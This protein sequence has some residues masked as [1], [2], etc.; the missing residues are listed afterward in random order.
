MSPL[1][2]IVIP[3][4]NAREKL[5]RSLD[6]IR[7]QNFADLEILVQDGASNDGTPAFLAAQ[8]DVLW[9]SE[10]D[11]GVYDAMNRAIARSTG[12]FLYFLGAGDCL[13]TGVID[14]IANVKNLHPL[15]L[16]YG[17]VFLENKGVEYGTHFE[18]CD[19]ARRNIPHQGAFYGRE[20]FNLLGSFNTKYSLL[21]DHDLNWRCFTNPRVEKRFIDL[22][23]A[24]Y[25]G[26][27]LSDIGVDLEFENDWPKLVWK[28]G[29]LTP[30][31]YL[32]LHKRFST[33]FLRKLGSFRSFFSH[34]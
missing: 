24:D 31:L 12:C 3:T 29:G 19:L 32:Q 33:K 15:L 1:F 5:E 6:S 22:V 30:W 8:S 17:K 9:V 18:L 34:R 21:S 7:A 27:G 14:C 13:H 2:S 16:I 10:P 25:E 11:A 20:I 23:I 28:Y 4:F 26:N